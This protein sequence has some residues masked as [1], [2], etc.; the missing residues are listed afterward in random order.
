MITPPSTGGL[1]NVGGAWLALCFLQ[2]EDHDREKQPW[3]CLWLRGGT[4]VSVP[5]Q[6]EFLVLE[7]SGREVVP[8]LIL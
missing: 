1:R 2:V 3:R 7:K 8:T 6:H 4:K 5:G